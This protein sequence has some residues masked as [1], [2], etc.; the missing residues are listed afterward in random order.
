MP[1]TSKLARSP[2]K[3]VANVLQFAESDFGRQAQLT[4]SNVAR[5][6][7]EGAR[8]AN[9][10]FMRFVEGEGSRGRAAPLDESRKDFWDDFADIGE[11][12]TASGGGTSTLGTAAM[13]K[14]RKK[15]DEWDW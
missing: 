8:N 5:Q 11:R 3:D 15:E 14:G 13:G 6:A 2:D 9:D 4:A 10:N 12:R 7:Q 1:I